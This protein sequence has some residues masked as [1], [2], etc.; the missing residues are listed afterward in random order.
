MNKDSGVDLK[1]L[2]VD[3]GMVLNELLM[4]FQSD[5]LDVP[6]IRPKVIETTALRSRLC[7]RAGHGLL[8]WQAIPEK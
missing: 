8:E 4:Q 2:K 6:I 3:G 7:C 1:H 5:I